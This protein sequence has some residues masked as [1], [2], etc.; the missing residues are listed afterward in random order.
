MEKLNMKE[1]EKYKIIKKWN[2][3]LIS[4][5]LTKKDRF[6]SPNYFP[7]QASKYFHQY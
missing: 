2:D 7:A 6:F 5:Q 4:C 1:K 3:N